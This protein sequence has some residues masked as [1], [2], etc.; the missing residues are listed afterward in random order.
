MNRSW[1]DGRS[2]SCMFLY[3]WDV[4]NRHK[5]CSITIFPMLKSFVAQCRHGEMLLKKRKGLSWGEKKIWTYRCLSFSFTKNDGLSTNAIHNNKDSF[6]FF[7][8]S[9]RNIGMFRWWWLLFPCFRWFSEKYIID[10]FTN[11]K[12]VI[13]LGNL[14]SKISSLQ[15]KITYSLTISINSSTVVYCVTANIR[16]SSSRPSLP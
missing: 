14:N 2:K 9:W 12:K 15:S 5:K 4:I 11:L 1:V 16:K 6:V 13:C 8:H 7:E 3:G 10:S